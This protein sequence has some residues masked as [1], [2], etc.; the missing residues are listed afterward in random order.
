MS[1]VSKIDWLHRS[2]YKVFG[3]LQNYRVGTP[4]PPDATYSILATQG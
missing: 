2:L 1:E 3:L 4:T